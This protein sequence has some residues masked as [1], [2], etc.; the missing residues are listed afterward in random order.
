MALALIGLQSLPMNFAYPAFAALLLLVGLALGLFAAPNTSAV[1][2]SLPANQRGAG[3]G[4][5]NTFQNS[6]SVLSIGFFFTVITLGL[7]AALPTA[8]L[9]GLTA[10]G[11]PVHAAQQISHL[12]RSAASSPPSSGSIPSI[13]S[14]AASSCPNPACTPPISPDGASSPT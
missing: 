2:N 6:A 12:R 9:N 7:A 13:S 1:M 10:Q 11:I 3:G 5:L 4:M 14:S 8:L